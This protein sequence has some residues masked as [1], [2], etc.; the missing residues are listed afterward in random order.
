MSNYD[1]TVK[2]LLIGGGISGLTLAY[3]LKEDFLIIEKDDSVGGYCRTIPHKE[4]IWDYAGHFYHFKTQ[5]FK[6]LFLSLVENDQ[7]I[8]QE[9]VTGIYYK[10]RIIDYPFQTNIHQLRREEFIDCL[11]DLYFKEEKEEYDNFL[12]M[13]Y[14]K[15]GRSI[16][17]KFLR[18]YNEKLYAT[19]LRNL[20]T[21]AMGRF[22]PYADFA[23][24]IRNM[25][26]G[27]NSSYNDHFLYIKK[28][29]QYFID[30]LKNKIDQS[31][32]ELN[33]EVIKVD[34]ERKVATL[35]DGRTV[36]YENLVNTSPLNFFLEKIDESISEGI[37][38]EMSYNKVLVLNLGFSKRSEKFNQEHWIYFPDKEINFY[39]VGFYNNILHTDK[40]SLYV[41]FGYPKDA[42]ITDKEVEKQLDLTLTNLKKVGI[43]DGEN[44]LV[45]HS[46]IIMDPA[47][48]HISGPTEE[49]IKKLNEK[50]NELNIFTTGR[51]GK[52]TYSSMEDCM[53]WAKE[54]SES[55]R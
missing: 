41:E 25:K 46:V 22:F 54:I 24:I 51:Y 2:T 40:L 7:I 14:G 44:T 1:C 19:D 5:E 55:I 31:K 30:K 32:I 21:N 28:G 3:F 16:V 48:V 37:L 8:T 13:L 23:G 10:D 12:D 42:V 26:E 33:T 35:S 50:L 6:N 27:R 43:T 47:Y 38:E 18:P 53:V 11:Y 9:K 15:F 4:Y 17:E 45:D 39:R 34:V 49:K 36:H 20:D 29:T 52:W